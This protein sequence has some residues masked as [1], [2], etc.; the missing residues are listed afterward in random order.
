MDIGGH[1]CPSRSYMIHEGMET[2]TLAGYGF[3][4]IPPNDDDNTPIIVNYYNA[5]N[6]NQR[7]TRCIN[8]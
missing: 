5:K 4:D 7:K 8:S 2:Q 3:V 6:R 1:Q